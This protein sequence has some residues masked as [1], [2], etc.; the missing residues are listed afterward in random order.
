MELP[1]QKTGL[2]TP[3]IGAEVRSVGSDSPLTIMMYGRMAGCDASDPAGLIS[4]LGPVQAV[5]VQLRRLSHRNRP[6]VYVQRLCLVSLRCSCSRACTHG[7]KR[8]AP[9]GRPSRNG[10][11]DRNGS[12]ALARHPACAPAAAPPVNAL[13]AARSRRGWRQ[14]RPRQARRLPRDRAG[15]PRRP[16][17]QT[18]SAAAAAAAIHPL[19]TAGRCCAERPP[20]RGP[21]RWI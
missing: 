2:S 12:G 19:F 1:R 15:H 9:V 13:R 3:A 11:G 6:E 21:P 20:P 8:C 17:N 5:A 18:T 14:R 7:A 16:P 4:S 10:S